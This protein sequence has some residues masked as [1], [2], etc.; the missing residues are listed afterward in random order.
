M[1]DLAKLEAMYEKEAELYRSHKEKA[2]RL[3]EKIDEEKGQALTRSIKPVKLSP[4][5]FLVLLKALADEKNVREMVALQMERQEAG[6]RKMPGETSDGGEVTDGTGN[7][8]GTPA[9]GD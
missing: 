5:E 1:S 4:E 6:K 7:G 9:K 3:K 2:D 8:Q